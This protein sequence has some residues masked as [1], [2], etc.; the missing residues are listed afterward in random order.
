ME[1][2]YDNDLNENLNAEQLKI[3]RAGEEWNFKQ[4]LRKRLDRREIGFA[5]KL[6]RTLE[7]EAD[8]WELV[9]TKMDGLQKKSL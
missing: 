1:V 8:K 2:K 5:E 6:L 9:N 3:K 4:R 7:K